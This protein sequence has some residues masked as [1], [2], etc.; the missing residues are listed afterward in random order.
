M[1]PEIL[2]KRFI[3]ILDTRNYWE[4]QRRNELLH[5]FVSELFGR[6]P[7]E[8]TL[9]LIESRLSDYFVGH[10]EKELWLGTGC[11]KMRI[12]LYLPSFENKYPV[13]LYMCLK[14]QDEAQVPIDS[15][16][17]NGFAVAVIFSEDIA[18]DDENAQQS[19]IFRLLD[20]HYIEKNCVGNLGAWAFGLEQAKKYLSKDENIL[21]DQIS[22]AGYSRGGKAALYACALYGGFYSCSAVHSGCGGASLFRGI[23]D[24]KER[25]SD[26]VS[27][28]P[29]WFVPEILK[30]QGRENSL[31]FDQHMLLALCAPVRLCILNADKDFWCDAEAEKASCRLASDIFNL[32]PQESSHI[33]Y[34]L[35]HGTH[36][37]DTFDWIEI[38]KVSK[39]Y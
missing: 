5:L 22:L 29:Y 21:S 28:F 10:K 34:K 14:G 17:D 3:K 20:E 37:M 31:P 38:M 25:L 18:S 39:K 1:I 27:S 2:D 7:A 19:G 8:I 13:I 16:L 9:S 35:R 26:I 30:Y 36:E 33:F 11:F 23:T 4:A 15:L 32:Y 6:V 12:K 24:E